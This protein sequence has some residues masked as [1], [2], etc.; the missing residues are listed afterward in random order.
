[1]TQTVK[2]IGIFVARPGKRDELVTLL[3]GLIGPSRSEPGNVRYDLWQDPT[4]PDQLV[5]DELY[6]DDDALAAHRETPHFRGYLATVNDLAE[7]TALALHAV[8][9]A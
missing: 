4:N 3:S 1:M 2:N 9:V 8:E 6:A 5:L 7:R